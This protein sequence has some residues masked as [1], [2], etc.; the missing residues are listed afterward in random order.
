MKKIA[1]LS[2]IVLIS[3]ISSTSFTVANTL[4]NSQQSQIYLTSK[5]LARAKL[6]DVSKISI[7]KLKIGMN[8][9]TVNRILGQ[10]NRKKVEN[11]NICHNSDITTLNYNRLEIGLLG[12]NSGQIFNIQTT[13]PAYRTSEGIRVGDPVSKAKKAYAKYQSQQDSEALRY[14]NQSY[15]GLSFITSQGVIT[16]IDLLSESC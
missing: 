5:K 4:S 2:S 7:G 13:N 6:I 15:G 12:K 10:P 14:V 11:D 3:S 8:M 16:E 1:L 9:Q